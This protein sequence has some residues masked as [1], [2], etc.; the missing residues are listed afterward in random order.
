MD[1][2]DKAEDNGGKQREKNGENQP[3]AE[4]D[5]AVRVRPG[6]PDSPRYEFRNPSSGKTNVGCDPVEQRKE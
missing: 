3:K 4:R 6:T 2:E 1:R 5:F